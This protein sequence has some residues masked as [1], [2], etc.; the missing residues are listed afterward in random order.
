MKRRVRFGRIWV[1]VLT[2]D[3]ALEAVSRLVH[4]RC[5]GRIFTPNVDHVILA[6]DQR[7]FRQ[8]YRRANL[9][10]A[11]G[12]PL[13]WA[14]RL[15]RHPLPAKLSGSD[16]LLPLARLAA[17]NDWGVYLLGG[18]PDAARLT[19]ERLRAECGVR[20]VGID[21]RA[22]TLDPE[23]D[24]HSLAVAAI[25]AARPELVFVALGSPKQELWIEQV[26]DQIQPAV[27]M[28][29]GAGL[30]FLAGHARRSPA[31]IS[32]IGLEWM[33]RL[34]QDPRRLWRRYLVRG[35]RFLCVISRMARMPASQRV[36]EAQDRTGKSRYT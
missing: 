31:W 3:E 21:D 2:H 15:L 35:P 34:V 10:F 7:A 11:D 18:L 29:V 23:S 13:I 26:I 28:G 22:L 12:V 14:S 24:A 16:M 8:A 19:A 4:A 6:E 20:V 17:L 33:H 27:A 36:R 9:S 30:D 5:G 25:R 1:D 32:R